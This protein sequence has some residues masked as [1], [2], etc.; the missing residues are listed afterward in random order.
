MARVLSPLPM[1]SLSTLLAVYHSVGHRAKITAVTW[2]STREGQRNIVPTEV[3]SVGMAC[4]C[5]RL[6]Q[7]SSSATGA[8]FCAMR[9]FV[10]TNLSYSLVCYLLLLTHCTR[11][12]TTISA[13]FA[14]CSFAHP[15]S[16]A[17]PTLPLVLH[18]R[19]CV[20]AATDD[21]SQGIS[22]FWALLHPCVSRAQPLQHA[23][24]CRLPMV[25]LPPK[26]NRVF[27]VSY[28]TLDAIEVA[29]ATGEGRDAPGYTS[30]PSPESSE[31]AVAED[32][33]GRTTSSK[34]VLAATLHVSRRRT[35]S[36]T[37]A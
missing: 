16:A 11:R 13:S 26:K 37:S 33:V 5:F 32:D 2:G 8:P 23:L 27:G 1:P 17:A 31:G 24:S 25:C 20:T 6:V 30:S 14:V 19:R 36:T 10:R 7:A 29:D 18:L 34:G 22:G 35:W 9:C 3:S 4:G 28:D 21:L 15:S 12:W